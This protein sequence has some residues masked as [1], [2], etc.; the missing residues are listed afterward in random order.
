MNKL[1]NVWLLLL[2]LV[3]FAA[4]S[5][6]E[7]D[8]QVVL[9][10]QEV[11]LPVNGGTGTFTVQTLGSWT[12]EAD[13][14][15][16]YTV[17]PMQGSG[18]TEVT[19]T[20]EPSTDVAS[21]SANLVVRC[22][23]SSASLVI[24]QIGTSNP[25]DPAEQEVFI[26]AKGGDKEVVL[27][28]NAG[29]DVMIPAEASWLTVKEEKTGSLV[30]S[31]AANE[32]TDQ[33]RTA[34]VSITK[35]D[36]SSLATLTVTQSWRNVEPGELLFQEIFLTSNVIAETGKVD[37]RSMEQYFILTNNTD[38]ELEIGGVA[39][40]ESEIA[41]WSSAQSNL[42]WNPD[43]RD[44]MAAYR[45]LY[46]IPADRGKHTLAAHESVLIVNNARNYKANNATSFD[47]SGADF[48]WY[49][50]STVSSMP[51]YDNPDVPNMDVWITY[52][53]TIFI[54]DSKS[55]RGY[56]I[57]SIPSNTT[58]DDLQNNEEYLWTGERSWTVAST[59]KDFSSQFSFNVLPN[60]WILDAVVVGT[61]EQ[62]EYT[63]FST[64]LDAGFTYC[65]VNDK[66]ESRYGKSM[67]RKKNADGTLVDTN[68]STND[69][70][71]AATAS[72]AE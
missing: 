28:A 47:L 69:F 72:L 67:I 21:R 70:T 45:A 54:L 56:F 33:N 42:V 36:G 51:D 10:T 18:A 60:D 14:Q 4:C 62:H 61:Q 58:A 55:C 7:N 3:G 17:S 37:T 59:G 13:G 6:D 30:L 24:T 32:N 26:R 5:D 31:A 2:L 22:G 44:E 48:E 25:S 8:A 34:E 9:S 49:D 52:T 29:Y 63:P 43:N 39:F 46:V 53:T 41:S 16:W 1:R 12:I 71:P 64:T 20:A 15:T 65:A 27:P 66:D 40:G 23:S 11:K 38:E 19:V 50:E 68:N 57:A 35:P